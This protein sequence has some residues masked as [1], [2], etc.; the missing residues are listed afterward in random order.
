MLTWAVQIRVVKVW[1]WVIDLNEKMKEAY[2]AD[3][4]KKAEAAETKHQAI[5]LTKRP[6]KGILR[7][8]T[9]SNPSHRAPQQTVRISCDESASPGSNPELNTDSEDV[10]LAA[11]VTG[12]FMAEMRDSAPPVPDPGGAAAGAS[13]IGPN[14]GLHF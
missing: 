3:R 6:S 14:G 5:D 7:N 9:D 1:C 11:V 2:M 13:Q 12:V 10:S 4:E 8:S